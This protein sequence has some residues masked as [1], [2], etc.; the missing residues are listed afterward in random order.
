MGIVLTQTNEKLF[1]INEIVRKLS[2][3]SEKIKISFVLHLMIL[4]RLPG[5]PG[6]PH[7]VGDGHDCHQ[8]VEHRV[9][10]LQHLQPASHRT[11]F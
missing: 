2:A 6:L 1:F 8:A 10:L 9:V 7:V 11:F 4:P 5:L 3:K